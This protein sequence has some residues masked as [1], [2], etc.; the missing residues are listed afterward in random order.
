MLSDSRPLALSAAVFANRFPKR[1]LLLRVGA[2]GAVF[3]E[4]VMSPEDVA[5]G[6]SGRRAIGENEGMLFVM[7]DVSHHPFWMRDTFVP[8]SIAFLS[9]DGTIQ[10]IRDMDP[11]SEERVIPARPS[12]LMLEVNRGWFDRRGLDVGD[13]VSIAS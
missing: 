9:E 1:R 10:E 11:L 12:R 5:R 4:V 13:V 6:L 8:L 3:V 2:R 7:R